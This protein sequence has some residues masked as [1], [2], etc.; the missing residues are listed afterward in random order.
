MGVQRRLIVPLA[1]FAAAIGVAACGED[2]FAN[3]PRPPAPIEL[4]ARI[5]TDGVTVSPGNAGAGLA[6]ITISNQTRDPARLVLEG[7]TDDA[8]DEILAGGTGAVKLAL[9]EG[10]YLVSDGEGERRTKLL[11]GPER[12]SS[13]NDLLLP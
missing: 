6:T 4:S 5:G 1:A 9:E 10:E 11:V 13:Q 7:P 8:S 3:E 12:E 2:D